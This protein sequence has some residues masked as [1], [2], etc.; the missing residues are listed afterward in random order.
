MLSPFYRLD[1]AGDIERA[2]VLTISVRT[3]GPEFLIGPGV[4]DPTNK[5]ILSCNASA[6]HGKGE[7]ANSL[8]VPGFPVD[9]RINLLV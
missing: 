1:P 7:A 8:S 2:D 9:F 5:P 4:T 6:A 3:S